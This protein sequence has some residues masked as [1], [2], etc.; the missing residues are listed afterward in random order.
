MT[1]RTAAFALLVVVAV[2]F[3]TVLYQRSD[4]V[5]EAAH[6]RVLEAIQ[7][8]G[9]TQALVREQVIEAR[10][11]LLNQFD[12]L[13]ETHAEAVMLDAELVDQV[14][15]G[16]LRN[17]GIDSALEELGRAT[18]ESGATLE[19]F[20]S[21]SAILKNSLFYLPTAGEL[22]TKGYGADL[23]HRAAARAPRGVDTRPGDAGLQPD[24][25]ARARV[26]AEAGPRGVA[27]GAFERETYTLQHW[28]NTA[29]GIWMDV[30]T[31]S[32]ENTS[33]VGGEFLTSNDQ[34]TFASNGDQIGNFQITDWNW[35]TET[36]EFSLTLTDLDFTWFDG[37]TQLFTGT[38][39]DAGLDHEFVNGFRIL[40]SFINY[41]TGSGLASLDSITVKNGAAIGKPLVFLDVTHDPETDT[42]TLTWDSEPD[43]VYAIDITTDLT[44]WPGDIE[45]SLPSQ[46]ETTSY[47]HT[48][49]TDEILFYR[50]RDVTDQQ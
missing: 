4:A 39:A 42:T 19:R 20:K 8:R 13:N 14:Q 38:Y 44:E 48:D 12:G 6:T 33:G 2:L 34:K 3:S 11:G 15:T 45:D 32:D 26:A 36:R 21:A 41:D 49:A 46:G 17:A 25:D 40:A 16:R 10:F 29:G 7:A 23:G 30:T 43:K 5:D 1:F 24:G 47:D 35:E 50:V 31:M 27:T 28:Q 18:T 37:E 22:A 9:R